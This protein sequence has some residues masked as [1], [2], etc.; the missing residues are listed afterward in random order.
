MKKFNPEKE[1]NKI[2]KGNKNKILYSIMAL[3][4]IVAVGSTY[5][6]YQVR[7]TNKI[8]YT[9]VDKFVNKDIILSVKL[10]D[11]DESVNEFPAA[12]SGYVYSHT[13]CEKGNITDI[14]WN[15]GQRSLNMNSKGP[16][17]CTVY[18]VKSPF[19]MKSCEDK[20]MAECLLEE[21][22]KFTNILAFDDPD[23]NGRYFGKD[24]ANYI[25]FNCD[26]YS[27]PTDKT[28][29]RWRIIGSFKN[30]EKANEDGSTIK[31]NLV[32]IIRNN[33]AGRASWDNKD[34][35]T[36]AELPVGMNDWSRAE[37]MY[38]LNP[39]NDNH[40]LNGTVANNSLYWNRESGKCSHGENNAL[41]SCDFNVNGLKKDSTAKYIEKVKWN[42]G[43]YITSQSVKLEEFYNYE[44]GTLTYENHS[45]Y[46][47]GF[48]ALIYPSDYGYSTS[49]GEK[50]RQYCLSGYMSQWNTD[51]AKICAANA[52][53][54]YT[55]ENGRLVPVVYRNTLTPDSSAAD[56]VFRVNNGSIENRYDPYG[57]QDIFPTLYLTYDTKVISGDGTYDNPYSIN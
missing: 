53:L 36:G 13:E 9:T 7:H 32:K 24:P 29:E 49:G 6:L 40:T 34:E 27:N 3:L 14:T 44:R 15:E 52:W 11:K 10:D 25:W 48:I 16:D 45:K 39:N 23:Q 30:I 21:G 31:Q 37:L 57:V 26:D 20:S 55:N 4:L 17:K 1:L 42:L 28:C 8:V 22:K 12:D 35:N 46:W 19:H 38:L 51:E 18:F 41:W 2:R 56:N 54:Y 47:N 43:G 5:A 33:T 50:G